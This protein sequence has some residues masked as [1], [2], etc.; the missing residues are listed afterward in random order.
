MIDE[1][2]QILNNHRLEVIE[3]K[4]F[5]DLLP[6]EYDFT[7]DTVKDCTKLAG[8]SNETY[9]VDFLYQ[10]NEFSVIIKKFVNKLVD[11]RIEHLIFQEL[12]DS[13]EGPY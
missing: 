9:K 3:S 7:T 11:F 5:K 12:S 8:A 1:C 2:V 13:L 4:I 6:T 10:E